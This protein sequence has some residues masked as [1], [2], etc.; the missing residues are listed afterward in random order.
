[1][2]QD[3][4]AAGLRVTWIPFDGGHEIPA[5]VVASLNEFLRG[6]RVVKP[7]S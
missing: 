2:Q 1:M 4:A 5:E 3:L 6:V 7:A